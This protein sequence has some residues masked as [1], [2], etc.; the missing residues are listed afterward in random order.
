M[1]SRKQLVKKHNDLI[2]ARYSLSVFETRI[3]LSIL[4]QINR[5]DIELSRCRIYIKD[6]VNLLETSSK[7]LYERARRVTKELMEKSLEIPTQTGFLQITWLAS[8]EY[9]WGEGYV[10]I[11]ISK[12]LKPYLLELKGKFTTYELKYIFPLQSSYSVRI[13][14]LLKQYY[15]E[16]IERTF[17]IEEF[18]LILQIG[19][20]YKLYAD[21]KKRVILQ[22]QKELK[23]HT[24]IYFEFKEIKT[25]RKISHIKFFIF[26]N[27]KETPQETTQQITNEQAAELTKLFNNKTLEHKIS[28][29][30]MLKIIKK[31]KVDY[32]KITELLKNITFNGQYSPIATLIAVLKG[33]YVLPDNNINAEYKKQIEEQNEKRKQEELAKE[34]ERRKREEE[35]NQVDN[36][37]NSLSATEQEELKQEAISIIKE[38]YFRENTNKGGL[39]F[40]L[41]DFMIKIKIR[42]L[43]RNREL[44]TV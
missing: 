21:L 8:V 4:T 27:Q 30:T 7:N 25:G 2:N 17:E 24:D 31:Y 43:I 22:A 18:K 11:E 19:N 44:Q 39:D 37:F 20:Q 42:E 35:A 15:S 16:I 3:I 1:D 32:E 23:E 38:K 6:F 13:Y 14:E 10:D 29:Q 41:T 26:S 12:Q 34:Q 28:E 5:I 33:S 40:L 9:Y 36:I